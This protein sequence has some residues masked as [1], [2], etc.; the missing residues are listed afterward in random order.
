MSS[1]LALGIF[2]PPSSSVCDRQKL[3]PAAARLLGKRAIKFSSH[4]LSRPTT[5]CSQL[6]KICLSCHMMTH[7]QSSVPQSQPPRSINQPPSLFTENMH[8]GINVHISSLLKLLHESMGGRLQ[9]LV[10]AGSNHVL[11]LSATALLLQP[12]PW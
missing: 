7:R 1:S 3:K 8:A 12:L 5:V 2:L 6:S 4:I 9:S 11:L 10:S